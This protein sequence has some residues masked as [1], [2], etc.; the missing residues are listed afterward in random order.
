M[1]TTTDEFLTFDEAAA[2]V[3]CTSAALRERWRRLKLP[4]VRFGPRRVLIERAVLMA[5]LREE[6][7][8]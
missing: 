8:T 1:S 3:R 6:S 7:I 4:V 5:Y 2:I